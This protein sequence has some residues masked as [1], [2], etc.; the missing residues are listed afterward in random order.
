MIDQQTYYGLL[1]SLLPAPVVARHALKYPA[2]QVLAIPNGV[3]FRW[4]GQKALRMEL[5]C[6]FIEEAVFGRYRVFRTDP[7][8]EAMTL[9][10]WIDEFRWLT[11][12]RHFD[13]PQPDVPQR[14]RSVIDANMSLLLPLGAVPYTHDF[15][16][17]T[18]LQ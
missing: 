17:K 10:E 4:L 9:I 6:C 8:T 5:E 7:L 16:L 11:R 3:I 15:V 14:C 1:A 18:R 12:K 13:P 2:T